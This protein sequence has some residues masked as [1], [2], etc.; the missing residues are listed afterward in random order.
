MNR[1]SFKGT[2]ASAIVLIARR[3]V[4]VCNA[5]RGANAMTMRRLAISGVPELSYF[6]ALVVVSGFLRVVTGEGNRDPTGPVNSSFEP[7]S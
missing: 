1:L 6:E 4:I 5:L 3:V 2:G 7:S